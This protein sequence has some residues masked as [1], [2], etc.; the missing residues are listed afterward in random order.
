MLERL[1]S[2]SL[3]LRE[4]GRGESQSKGRVGQMGM[5]WSNIQFTSST[6][7]LQVLNGIRIVAKSCKQP[8]HV[9]FSPGKET[10]KN[11][12]WED[13]RCSYKFR[14]PQNLAWR[15][16]KYWKEGNIFTWDY[17]ARLPPPPP[18]PKKGV[19]RRGT[20]WNKSRLYSKFCLP[21]LY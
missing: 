2:I 12:P 7:R 9:Q 18:P 16:Y 17:L 15:H 14:K 4:K 1:E 8:L 11:I 10:N 5:K 6:A 20:V 21:S 3:L 13:L 19:Y